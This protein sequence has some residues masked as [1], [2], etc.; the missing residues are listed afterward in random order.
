MEYLW[1]FLL[2]FGDFSINFESFFYNPN[3]FIV[4]ILPNHLEY[5]KLFLI[6][7]LLRFLYQNFRHRGNPFLIQFFYFFRHSLPT[8]LHKLRFPFASPR[9]SRPYMP[10]VGIY[11]NLILL[12]NL[13]HK[14]NRVLNPVWNVCNIRLLL[15]GKSYRLICYKHRLHRR[16]KLLSENELIYEL[17]WLLGFLSYRNDLVLYSLYCPWKI[18][19]RDNRLI[20]IV[21]VR[22]QLFPL[23]QCRL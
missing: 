9:I 8:E 3:F 16:W 23:G 14:W 5:L 21:R 7:I 18:K 20:L 10:Q 12:W 1:R 15:V 11:E 22:E 2:C 6:L 4:L 17:L 19:V 13:S